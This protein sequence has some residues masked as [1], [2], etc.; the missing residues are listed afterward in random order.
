M[1]ML[2]SLE[3]LLDSVTTICE[4]TILCLSFQEKVAKEVLHAYSLSKM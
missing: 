2:C 3:D 1:H 4:Y